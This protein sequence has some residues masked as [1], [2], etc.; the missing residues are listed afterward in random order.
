MTSKLRLVAGLLPQGIDEAVEYP[1][2][3]LKYVTDYGAPTAEGT[4]ELWDLTDDE[5]ASGL[6]VGS[7]SLSGNVVTS[8]IVTGLTLGHRYQLTQAANFTG[9]VIFS[10]F[11]LIQAER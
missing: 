4:V 6:L 8:S 7:P 3:F 9:G 1:F 10:G 5:D 2:D 11:L